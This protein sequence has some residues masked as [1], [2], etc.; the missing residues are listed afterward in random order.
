M[1]VRR[2]LSTVVVLALMF[3]VSSRAA[4]PDRESKLF[5][6][7]SGVER[8]L[9]GVPQHK[10]AAGSLV[11]IPP[12]GQFVVEIQRALRGPGR[13]STSVMV[14]NGGNEK[15]HPKF[16]NGK[17]Y[18]FL[19]K[20]N[21]DGKGW[22]NLGT[23]EIPIKDGKVQYIAG[24]S[25]S[26]FSLLPPENATGNYVKVVQRIPVRVR[27]DTTGKDLPSS[28]DAGAKPITGRFVVWDP[29]R[30]LVMTWEAERPPDRSA[31]PRAI[32]RC[33]PKR[34]ARRVTTKSATR[35]AKVPR[36]APT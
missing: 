36:P 16:V 18:V 22:I 19:L 20:K 6:A 32:L 2:S 13:K 34:V 10:G 23:S 33:R 12:G 24:A 35:T 28:Y 11:D 21:P 26:L 4:E 31:V 25:G 17:S 7:A 8:I 15:Q 5:G 1:P 3:A 30:F 27:V 9:I 29:D 14:I